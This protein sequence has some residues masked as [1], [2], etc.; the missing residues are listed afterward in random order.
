[1]ADVTTYVELD[2]HQ[3]SIA[4]ARLTGRPLEISG[5]PNDRPAAR[6]LAWRL[7]R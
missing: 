2:V 1:M 6:R 5:I 7:R 4:V 3:A